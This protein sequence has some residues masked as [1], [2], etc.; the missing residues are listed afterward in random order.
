MDNRGHPYAVHDCEDNMTFRP[1]RWPLRRLTIF[2]VLCLTGVESVVKTAVRVIAVMMA[3]VGST[4]ATCRAEPTKLPPEQSQIDW[5]HLEVP[6]GPVAGTENV[7]K[8]AI[9]LPCEPEKSII[10]EDREKRFVWRGSTL[11]PEY[12]YSLEVLA[13]TVNDKWKPEDLTARIAELWKADKRLKGEPGVLPV[14]LK[15]M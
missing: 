12:S 4:T 2:T 13:F 9:D 10:G 14:P 6:L 7:F 11:V 15:D 8:L 1:S 3:L 5:R